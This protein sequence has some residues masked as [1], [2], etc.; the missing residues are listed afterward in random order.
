MCL[1]FHFKLKS[2]RETDSL[3]YKGRL[4]QALA[5]LGKKRKFKRIS[6]SIYNLKIDFL[7]PVNNESVNTRTVTNT[8]DFPGSAEW[9]PLINAKNDVPAFNMQNIVCYFIDRKTKD[10]E[11]N[12]DYKNVSNKAF[13]LFKHGHVQNIEIST[14]IDRVYFRCDCLPEMKKNLKYKLK[15]SL[16]KSGDHS[17]EIVYASCPCP[18]GKGPLGSCKHVAAICY[19]LEECTRLNSTREFETCTSIIIIKTLLTCQKILVYSVW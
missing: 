3:M 6:P 11:A 19:A 14:D 7:I 17:G 9:T 15:L 13:G 8:I 5:T 1:Q 16:L 2:G 18:A 12:K 4:F 10:E